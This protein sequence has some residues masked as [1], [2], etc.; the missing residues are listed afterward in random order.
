MR[1][2][3]LPNAADDEQIKTGQAPVTG[4]GPEPIKKSRTSPSLGQ[5]PSIGQVPTTDQESSNKYTQQQ[6]Q[7]RM[8]EAFAAESESNERHDVP[9]EIFAMPNVESEME[10]ENPLCAFKAK[11]DPDTMYLHEALKQPDRKEFIQAMDKELQDQLKHGNFTVVHKSTVPEGATVLPTVWAMRRKR[12]QDTGEIYK[13]KGRLNVDGSKQQKG[14]NF[15]ETFAPVATWASIRFILVLTLIHG[16]KT[17]QIDYVQAYTQA[18]APLDD[19]YVKVP[20]GVDV[21]NGKREDYVMKVNKNVYGTHQAGRVWN[22]FLVSKLESIGFIQSQIDE[23][24]FYCGR[25]I[26]VLYTDDSILVGPD[27]DELDAIINNMQT[28]GLGITVEG[29]I[30]DFLGVNID[31]RDDGTIHLTQP[32]LIDQILKEMR[33][34]SDNVKVR[35]TPAAVSKILKRMSDS[36]DFDKHFNYRSIIGKLNFLEKSTRPDI[37]HAVHQ[38]ARFS[39]NPKQE[40]GKAVEWL[41]RYLAGTRDKGIIYHPKDKS[42]DVYVDAD[43]AGNWDRDEAADDADTARSRSAFVIMYAGCPILWGSKLQTLIALSST[44]SEYYSLSTATREV[45]PIMELAKEMQ[46]H[47]FDIGTTQPKIHCKVFEDNSGALEIAT[48]HKVR[49]RTKHMNVQYHHFRH[50]VNTG[51][52]SIHPIDT[53]DQPADML[54]K[55]VSLDK[56][57]KHRLFI[58]GW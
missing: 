8:L 16:W 13:Y 25:C 49:P 48:V 55:S 2:Q 28:V 38:A 32:R 14:I 12:K 10:S 5:V 53:D 47:G 4:D 44:E 11:T 43:F 35:Q 17:R 58:M 23:C 31:R 41:C 3:D 57:V 39:A 7:Q 54:S 27:D 50:H 40:H 26:Y 6:V 9:Y 45:I 52:M 15:W 24:V 33:L 21:E 18:D 36:E 37:S 20:K 34:H 1:S 22:K 42:F 30:D 46:Q 56:L 19:L 29:G 51:Q